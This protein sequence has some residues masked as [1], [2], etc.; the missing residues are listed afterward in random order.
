MITRI[1]IDNFRCFSNFDMKPGRVNLLLGLNGSGK[2]SFV[3]AIDGLLAMVLDGRE[4]A[5]TFSTDD[6]TRWDSRREQ[7]F[8]LE[9]E[10]DSEV[11]AYRAILK[12]T[13]V[14]GALA[15]DTERVVCG[16]RVLFRYQD[17]EVHLHRND[18]SEGTSFLF[19]GNRSF[20]A[21]IEER[22]ETLSLFR[23]K[24]Y[25]GTLRSY[26]INPSTMGS[27]TQQ[28]QE[29]LQKDGS[30]FASW[31]RHIAQERAGDI[32]GLF[33]RLVEV[34]PGFRSI[35]L[36]GAGR[37]GRTR[38][39]VVQMEA[40]GESYELDFDALSD[41]QRAL[42]VLYSLLVEVSAGSQTLFMDEPENYVGL[43]ELQPWLQ[44]LDDALGDSGQLFL[45]SHNPEVIDFLASE[46]PFVFERAGAGPVQVRRAQFD[47]DGG[48]RASDQIA[49]GFLDVE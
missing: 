30:N 41:G 38:D 26:K 2:S 37:Q 7:R 33:E 14:S 23:F 36:K 9:V 19:R 29:N 22:Q 44:S 3:A 4:V 18:G 11:F 47:R 12:P 46:T 21:E 34:L 17:G 45:I 10:I 35:A 6:L 27:V 31:Y 48:L 40:G 28:E 16:P 32:P 25:L 1:Y 13:G 43:S 5:E 42:I 49:R 15:L 8:E 20:I 39:V 24:D